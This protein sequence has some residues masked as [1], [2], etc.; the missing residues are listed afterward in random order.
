MLSFS[1]ENYR[2]FAERATLQL[3]DNVMAHRRKSLAKGH[4]WEQHVEPVAG[5]FGANASGKSTL[6]QALSEFLQIFSLKL[7]K[8]PDELY[9]PF[10]LSSEYE[11]KPTFY[12]LDF[13]HKEQRWV[14]DVSVDGNGVCSE[15][16][17]T[18]KN[19][20]RVE[21]LK[22]D[23]AEGI[24]EMSIPGADAKTVSLF[25]NFLSRNSGL[26]LPIILRIDP[27]SETLL[28]PDFLSESF[29]FIW[30]DEAN[31]ETRHRWLTRKILRQSQWVDIV[32]EVLQMADLGIEHFSIHEGETK[33][34][35]LDTAERFNRFID[36]SIDEGDYLDRVDDKQIET[37]AD[38]LVLHH[39]MK[40]GGSKH[41]KFEEESRGTI[42]WLNLAVPAIFVLL[43]GGVLVCDE[44]DDSL[45]PQLVRLIVD[46][47][48]NPD[49]NTLNAQL[50]F[51][52][53]DAG[54]LENYPDC[55][56]ED[57]QIW[58]TE[59]DNEGKAELYLLPSGIRKG[60]NY[61]KRYI[62]GAMG[63]IPH[64]RSGDL[65]ELIEELREE[66]V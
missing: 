56:L 21:V 54:L 20:Q 5:I 35:N 26:A 11:D 32:I 47:Y 34:K 22:K 37:V 58:F 6:L 65:Q 13:V 17:T 40:D 33:Q 10:R 41:L 48:Q 8:T 15:T 66:D 42:A 62:Q 18:W 30:P 46:L 63:A 23:R 31:K 38:A 44:I 25:V 28:L 39:S 3:A 19:T 12:S 50:V 24:L 9:H 60:T 49:I 52:T 59:K 55:A 57:K 43:N 53:H 36:D 7:F 51:N 16:L 45:H 64:V 29:T 61:A 1:V 14:Y 27:L 2:C 4:T